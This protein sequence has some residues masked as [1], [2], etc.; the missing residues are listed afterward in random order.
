[1]AEYGIQRALEERL[2]QRD[3]DDNWDPAEHA[4]PSRFQEARAAY[5][6]ALA[7]LEHAETTAR[8]SGNERG[9]ESTLAQL[10]RKVRAAEALFKQEQQRVEASRAATPEA[11]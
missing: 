1:M 3:Q 7:E 2:D 8:N 9:F 10:R 4:P 5:R 6:W 11:S